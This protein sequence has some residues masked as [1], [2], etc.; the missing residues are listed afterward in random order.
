MA[1]SYRVSLYL[2]AFLLLQC[3]TYELEFSECTTEEQ[4]I[5]WV[6]AK[7]ENSEKIDKNTISVVAVVRRA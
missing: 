1:S 4:A 2:F 7:L 6:R 5:D 3:V